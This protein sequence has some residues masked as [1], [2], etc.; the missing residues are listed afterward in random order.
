MSRRKRKNA[1]TLITLLLAMIALIVFYIWYSKEP[2][3]GGSDKQDTVEGTEGS[4][5][6]SAADNLELAKMD[7][8]LINSI[9]LINQAADL[10]L[11]L[12]DSVWSSEAEPERPINQE[13]VVD[14]LSLAA[15]VKADKLI[16]T[17]PEDPAEYGLAEPAIYFEAVQSDGTSLRI[18][19]GDKAITGDG[20]YAQVNDS[21]AV[22]LLDSSYGT[23]MAYSTPDMTAIENAPVIEADSI[24]HI[25]LEKREGN[26]F[27]LRYDTTNTVDKTGSGMFPWVVLQPYEEGYSA[28]N[29]KVSDLLP[30][31]ASFKLLKNVDYTGKNLSQYGLE[32]PAAAIT[33]GYYEYYTQTLDKPETDPNTG[34]EITEKTYYDE[35]SYKIYVGDRDDGENYYVR[36]EGSNS[37]YTMKAEVVEKMLQTD[38]FSILSSFV[39][40]PNI[41][42][43]DK[44]EIN[45]DGQ[46]YTME[47]KRETIKNDAG[48]EEKKATYYYNGK[49]ASED[50]FKDVYQIM[51]GAGYDKEI[52]ETVDEAKLRPTLSITYYLTNGNSLT[53]SYLPYNDSFYIVKTQ[54]NPIRFFTDKREIEEIK[55][56]IKEF[57]GTGE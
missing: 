45:I 8:T 32:D 6:Q 18:S 34:Q 48:E 26:N 27:E 2:G 54:D 19:I 15:V 28:E 14:L 33:V 51:I 57:K 7:T 3:K 38:P 37:V 29:S 42:T 13:K 55:H 16:M 9:R 49:E 47:I 30:N 1:I 20:Y 4:T 35:K 17:R 31:F 11:I 41:D 25:K 24:Y 50:V 56:T 39:I 5:N 10:K 21:E 40:I 12:K 52:L 44:I 36:P 22:Y 23:R 43:V 53:S 46:P